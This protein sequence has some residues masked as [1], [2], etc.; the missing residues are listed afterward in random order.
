MK[1]K[2]RGVR[3]VY[4]VDVNR[5]RLETLGGGGGGDHRRLER[6]EAIFTSRELIPHAILLVVI[7][8]ARVQI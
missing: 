6:G 3:K 1:Q 2:G 8:I 5:V 7:Y 4:V